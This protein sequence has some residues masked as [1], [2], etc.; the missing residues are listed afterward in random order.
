[1][2][3]SKRLGAGLLIGDV[4]R[5][6]GISTRAVRHYHSA[7]LLAEPARDSSGYRRYGTVEVIALVRIARLR[8]L[9]MPVPTISARLNAGDGKVVTD[10]LKALA[11]ELTAEIVRLTQLRDRIAAAVDAQTLADPGSALAA[12]LREYGRLG[13]EDDL[14]PAVAEAARLIDA[15]HPGG[16]AGAIDAAQALLTDPGKVVVL[17][18]LL[19]R[20]RAFTDTTDAAEIHALA[21]GVA[22]LLPHPD[23]A[24][25]PVE[26][27]VMDGLLGDRLNAGQRHFMVELRRLL[28]DENA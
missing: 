5:L 4:A 26:I 24:P 15:L 14:T 9:G 1:M 18:G 16:M 6:C 13:D 3:A 12:A 20:V 28:D 11:D 21:A 27:A 25:P 23:E 2:T 10:D 19:R 17:D 7:G 22:A 8:A